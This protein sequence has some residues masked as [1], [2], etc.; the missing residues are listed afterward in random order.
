MTTSRRAVTTAIVRDLLLVLIALDR[1]VFVRAGST[2]HACGAQ[3]HRAGEH[4]D[5]DEDD[6]PGHPYPDRHG[7][8]SPNWALEQ[9]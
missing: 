8:S 5:Q 1:C 4:T 6:D 3:K 7:P 9:R 2:A